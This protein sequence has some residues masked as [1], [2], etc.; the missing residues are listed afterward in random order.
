MTH[1]PKT[2]KPRRL[3]GTVTSDKMQKTRVIAVSRMKRHPKY[4]KYYKV[5]STFKAHDAENAY[6]VDDQVMIQES[7]PLSRDKRW[8]IVGKVTSR[9]STRSTE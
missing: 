1:S 8:V 9:A 3:Q 6:H 4:L 7:R 2:T 5:T